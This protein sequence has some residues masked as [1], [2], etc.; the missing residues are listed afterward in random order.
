MDIVVLIFFILKFVEMSVLSPTVT[1][2][3]KCYF[4]SEIIITVLVSHLSSFDH[5]T[6]GQIQPIDFR[7]SN[8]LEQIGKEFHLACSFFLLILQEM[9]KDKKI[10][11]V[12]STS[13]FSVTLLSI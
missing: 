5:A 9:Q 10:N 8:F 2:I 6:K 4:I 12:L 11:V 3:R 1:I 13:F 7:K